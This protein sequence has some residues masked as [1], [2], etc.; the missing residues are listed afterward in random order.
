LVLAGRFKIGTRPGRPYLT[1]RQG[2]EKPSPARP[3]GSRAP[4]ACKVEVCVRLATMLRNRERR[5][6]LP[7]QATMMK[8]ISPAIFVGT[9]D[10]LV[11]FRRRRGAVGAQRKE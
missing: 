6:R 1:L 2:F 9:A 8:S 11:R 4:R 3:A 7:S 5:S 10:A